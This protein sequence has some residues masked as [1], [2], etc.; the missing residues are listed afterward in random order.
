MPQ[1]PEVTHVS[2]RE[3][4]LRITLS[5][6][7]GETMGAGEGGIVGFF[8]DGKRAWIESMG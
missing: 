6:T 7:V 8:T 1:L 3:A 2:K 5:K 4:G